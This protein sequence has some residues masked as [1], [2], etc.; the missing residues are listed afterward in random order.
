LETL[1]HDEN[2]IILRDF[3][4]SPSKLK[5]TINAA[6]KQFSN[7]KLIAV[8]ELHTFSSLNPE[9]LKEYVNTMNEADVAMVYFNPQTLIHKKLNPI[10]VNELAVIFNRKDLLVFTNEKE[11]MNRVATEI[12]EKSCILFMSSGTF[13]GVNLNE[14]AIELAAL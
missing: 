2:K 5:A 6:K 13:N 11:L 9:F 12:K 8:Y 7:F 4:H 10:D 14:L 1:H 3:A